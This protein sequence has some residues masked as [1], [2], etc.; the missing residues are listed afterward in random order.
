[1]PSTRFLPPFNCSLWAKLQALSPQSSD[2]GGLFQR[3]SAA[4]GLADTGD[5]HQ[6]L[7]GVRT[8]EARQFGQG[9]RVRVVDAAAPFVRR[10]IK[11]AFDGYQQDEFA[12]VSGSL[13]QPQYDR[14]RRC[15]LDSGRGWR[16]RRRGF[17]D[18]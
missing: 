17:R 1:M 13:S 5:D 8:D 6:A 12:A 14:P 11:N 15:S 3:G 18:E 16:Q 9:A 7:D 4:V 2:E 10:V